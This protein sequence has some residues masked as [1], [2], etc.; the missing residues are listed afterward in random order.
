MNV[1]NLAARLRNAALVATGGGLALGTLL[2]ASTVLLRAV[3]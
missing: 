1:R 3:L 2:L